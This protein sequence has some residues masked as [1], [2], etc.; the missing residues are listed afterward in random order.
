MRI[1]IPARITKHP[2]IEFRQ[3]EGV[4]EAVAVL[5]WVG[6]IIDIA[7]K[8][9]DAVEEEEEGEFLPIPKPKARF[10]EEEKRARDEKFL[11]ACADLCGYYTSDDDK[12]VD[13]EKGTLRNHCC[14]SCQTCA[15]CGGERGRGRGSS[16][17]TQRRDGEGWKVDQRV[18]WDDL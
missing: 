7:Q 2:S 18:R 11:A 16:G 1:A 17:R 9:L 13:V 10:T 4:K 14:W 15:F 12:V 5:R 6:W 3:H 8:A